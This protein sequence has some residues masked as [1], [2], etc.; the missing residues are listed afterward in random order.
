MLFKKRVDEDLERIRKANLPDTDVG[1]EIKTNVE[2]VKLEKGDLPAM[3]LAVL[4][5]VLPYVLAFTAIMA[6]VVFV[7]GV[8][9]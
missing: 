7:L 5:I 8:L 1:E 3:I 6:G 4:S 2:K 9:F